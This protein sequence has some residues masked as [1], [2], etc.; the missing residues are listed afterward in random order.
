MPRV[1]VKEILSAPVATVWPLISTFG[2]ISAWAP[3]AKIVHI[4]GSAVG[5]VR[6]VDTAFG[7]FVERC[8]A[9]DP[10]QYIFSYR[11][12][13]SPSPMR[14]YVAVVRLTA[15]GPDE[16]Q[17]EWS[18]EFAPVGDTDG[19]RLAANIEKMYRSAFIAELRRTLERIRASQ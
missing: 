9:Y 15:L 17:I 2:D 3:A 12:L 14:D 5:A 16:C 19:D 13:E 18:S 11:V 8:E 6:R 10:L 4:D 1:H 7:T